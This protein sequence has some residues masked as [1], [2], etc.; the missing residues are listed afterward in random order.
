MPN[1]LRALRQA[2]GLTILGVAVPAHTAPSTIVA[3]EKYDYV[4]GR[5]VKERLAAALSVAVSDVWPGD[6]AAS[7]RRSPSG[8][9]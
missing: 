5:S 2:R 3:I 6:D 8:T 7:D 4:P 1:A 9:V